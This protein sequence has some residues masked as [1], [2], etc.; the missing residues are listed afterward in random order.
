MKEYEMFWYF[1]WINAD[2]CIVIH[3]FCLPVSFFIFFCVILV[4]FYMFF[5]ICYVFMIKIIKAIHRKVVL[6]PT[7]VAG[8]LTSLQNQQIR[9]SHPLHAVIGQRCAAVKEA[10][11]WTSLSSSLFFILHTTIS[12]TFWCEEMSA[13]LWL[14]ERQSENMCTYPHT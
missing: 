10:R 2:Q 12:V 4:F 13:T 9:H 5:V 7:S 11:V 1:H 6:C 14:Y 3:L 8:V